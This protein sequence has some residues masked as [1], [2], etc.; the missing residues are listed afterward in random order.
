MNLFSESVADLEETAEETS[1]DNPEQEAEIEA[2][3]TEELESDELEEPENDDESNED[4]D[5]EED[6]YIIDGVEYSQEDLQAAKDNK[7]MQADYTKKTMLLAD[8]R[9][10][11]ESERDSLSNLAAELQ[12]LVD[13]DK[14]VDWEKLKEDD[15]YE[16][17][18]LKEKADARVAKL[19]EAKSKLTP[20]DKMSNEVVKEEQDL[21]FKSFPEWT[22]K[23]ENGNVLELTPQYYSDIKA[24][25]KHGKE[26]GFT[27]EQLTGV[28][29][30]AMLKAL[31]NSM[32]LGEKK[33]KIK[34]AKKKVTPKQS[35]P[36]KAGKPSQ[37][38]S[39]FNKS[40]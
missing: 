13:E 8:E 19:E 33:E 12:V 31:M 4:G 18:E 20:T 7:N 39:L 11:T 16:Y 17:V 38:T 26:L 36:A 15:P 21:M 34:I 27:D 29:T 24:L 22:T 5:D 14:D 23:D 25:S 2:E 3:S 40:A 30:A 28:N 32:K 35:K 9:K 6:T 10:A 37:S 1:V